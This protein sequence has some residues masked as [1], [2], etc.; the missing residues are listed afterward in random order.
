[1]TSITFSFILA[2]AK[3]LVKKGII[4]KKGLV[5]EFKKI[6]K[7]IKSGGPMTTGDEEVMKFLGIK[8]K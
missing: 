4:D 3:V 1:M 7:V 5:E 8:E 6:R 2:F